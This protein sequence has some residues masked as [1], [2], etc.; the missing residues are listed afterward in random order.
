MSAWS[1]YKRSTLS[2]RH[3]SP[4]ID[5]T[6]HTRPFIFSTALQTFTNNTVSCSGGCAL[7]YLTFGPHSTLRTDAVAQSVETALLSDLRADTYLPFSR[8]MCSVCLLVSRLVSR[9]I[10]AR[11]FT[12]GYRLSEP[13][14][15][16]LLCASHGY[17]CA[18]AEP[19]RLP[20]FGRQNR[21]KNRRSVSYLSQRFLDCKHQC[22]L[23]TSK[24]A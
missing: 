10:A 15:F 7:L 24:L 8:Y 3:G 13:R 14:A 6:Q 4:P 23:R 9:L 2:P 12:G 21:M 5:H 17:R 20:D 22:R 16:Q 1:T 19:H 11:G 18:Q